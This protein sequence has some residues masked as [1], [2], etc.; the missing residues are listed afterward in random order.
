MTDLVMACP[1]V[2]NQLFRMEYDPEVARKLNVAAE[3]DRFEAEHW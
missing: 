1:N 2:R 3:R